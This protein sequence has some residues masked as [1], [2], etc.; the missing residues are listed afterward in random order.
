[1]TSIE[2]SA[3]RGL[4]ALPL[5]A[6]GLLVGTWSHQPPPQTDIGAW[7]RYVTTPEFLYSH[8]FASILGGAVGMIGIAAL[9]MLLVARGSV[10]LGLWA[11]VTGLVGNTLV[12]PLFGIAAWAQ[13]AI[14]RVYLSGDAAAAQALYYDAAQPPTLVLTG[15][16]A[17]LLL[18]A[19]TVLFGIA[20]ARSRWLPAW[21]GIALAV[22]GPLVFL[23]GFVLDNFVQTIGS[24]LLIVSTVW[25]ALVAARE[26]EPA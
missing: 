23:V 18:T 16:V 10:R 11:M 24:A 17:V 5:W 25:I 9:G 7:S 22:A 6:L 12:A 19:S 1:M 26:A 14:G 13:P 15:V 21:A 3:R 8:L 20:V 2:R 4:W